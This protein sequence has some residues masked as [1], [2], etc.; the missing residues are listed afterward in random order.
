VQI[1]YNRAEYQTQKGY[2]LWL[3]LE[4]IADTQLSFANMSL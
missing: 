1:S 2:Y 4:S 3:W